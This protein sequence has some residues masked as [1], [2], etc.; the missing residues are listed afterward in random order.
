M[1]SF[2]YAQN[3]HNS[4]HVTMLWCDLVKTIENVCTCVKYNMH[5]KEKTQFHYYK[6]IRNTL[7]LCSYEVFTS[8]Q[9]ER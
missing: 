8:N 2:L 1:K 5:A 6:L 3:E 4:A 9:H 7:Q